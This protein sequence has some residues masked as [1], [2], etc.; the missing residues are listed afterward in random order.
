MSWTY[1]HINLRRL[2]RKVLRF[3]ISAR[4]LKKSK[5]FLK[6]AL[7]G[8]S[9]LVFFSAYQPAFKFPPVKSSVVKAQDAT[10]TQIIEASKAPITFQ[11]PM[12]GYL[13]TPF[14]T[15]HPGID[16]ATGLGMPIKPISKG[17]VTEVGYNFWGL[18]LIV[19][20]N[21][22]LG[23]KSLYAHMGKTYVSKGQE[24]SEDNFLGEVGLTGN[25]SGPH[26]HL[27]VSKDNQKIDPRII[28]PKLREYPEESDFIALSNDRSSTT[29]IPYTSVPTPTPVSTPKP[30]PPPTTQEILNQPLP[31]NNLNQTSTSLVNNL[32][33]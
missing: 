4:T 9:C 16:I 32:S 26:T 3:K 23:Y 17:I 2:A 13:S 25:T 20:V 24:V 11:L 5:V 30:T 28:L 33:L 12:P 21:H 1:K 29:S 31:V 8:I 14:S 18:G 22:G 19:E 27:E 15:F 7:G 6:I 10:Q